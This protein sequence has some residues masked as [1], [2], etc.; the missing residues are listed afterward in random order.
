MKFICNIN[1]K[2]EPET[3]AKAEDCVQCEIPRILKNTFTTDR[4]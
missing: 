4:K 1:K 3:A 2:K